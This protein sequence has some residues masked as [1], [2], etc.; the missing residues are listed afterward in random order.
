M[1]INSTVLPPGSNDG[2]MVIVIGCEQRRDRTIQVLGARK[3]IATVSIPDCLGETKARGGKEYW[4]QTFALV[5][6]SHP[7]LIE[8]CECMS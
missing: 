8:G 3:A 5:R 7:V 2:F 4:R 1:Q 6:N